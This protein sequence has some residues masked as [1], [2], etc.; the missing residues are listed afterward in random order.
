MFWMQKDMPMLGK[1]DMPILRAAGRSG[2]LSEKTAKYEIRW[3]RVAAVADPLTV[4]RMET[5]MSENPKRESPKKKATQKMSSLLD[6]LNTLM[7]TMRVMM[8]DMMKMRTMKKANQLR[9]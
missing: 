1:R 4:G 8:I 7:L 3:R 5:T 6:R 9:K 2:S